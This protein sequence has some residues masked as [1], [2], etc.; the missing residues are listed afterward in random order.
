MV[1]NR[2]K[3]DRRIRTPPAR[4]FPRVILITVPSWDYY[5]FTIS[6]PDLWPRIYCSRVTTGRKIGN[7]HKYEPAIWGGGGGPQGKVMVFTLRSGDFNLH[8]S[9]VCSWRTKLNKTNR[10]Y[11]CNPVKT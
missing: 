4:N 7:C 6:S 10:F 5:T 11:F 3:A 2:S 8:D 9:E 1:R